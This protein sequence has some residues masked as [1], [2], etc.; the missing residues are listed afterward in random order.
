M[1]PIFQSFNSQLFSRSILIKVYLFLTLSWLGYFSL[2]IYF[3]E[4]VW[5]GGMCNFYNN[6]FD[7]GFLEPCKHTI[8]LKTTINLV[9]LWKKMIFFNELYVKNNIYFYFLH[10]HTHSYTIIRLLV[11]W[12]VNTSYTFIFFCACVLLRPCVNVKE[13]A[14]CEHIIHIHIFLRMRIITSLCECVRI[15]WM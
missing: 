12:N 7:I 6:C 10:I 11:N 8:I 9:L 1:G 4:S 14:E 5:F 15:C 13:Y 3:I 2:S